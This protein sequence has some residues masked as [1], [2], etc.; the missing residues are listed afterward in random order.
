MAAEGAGNENLVG[1]N[2]DLRATETVQQIAAATG[3]SVAAV[4]AP[5]HGRS[6]IIAPEK[7]INAAIARA[8]VNAAVSDIR[9]VLNSVH[10]TTGE[11]AKFED[12]H[13]EDHAIVKSKDPAQIKNL[14]EWILA[15]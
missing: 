2:I 15:Q 12:G 6:K 4:I 1:V 10:I 3:S 11:K 14:V 9:P 13:E 5:S 8:T 7:P